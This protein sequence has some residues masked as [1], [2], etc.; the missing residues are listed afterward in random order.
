MSER[1]FWLVRHIS[2]SW[3]RNDLGNQRSLNNTTLP[4]ILSGITL[5]KTYSTALFLTCSRHST[6]FSIKFANKIRKLCIPY[7][8]HTTKMMMLAHSIH[9]NILLLSEWNERVSTLA[10]LSHMPLVKPEWFGN[11][12]EKL[13]TK[14]PATAL[15]YLTSNSNSTVIQP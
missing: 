13:S 4:F 15:F 3:N 8:I 6:V 14:L 2:H 10:S 11:S 1:I 12:F 9:S 5:N 7:K